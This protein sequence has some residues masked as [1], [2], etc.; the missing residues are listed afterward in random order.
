LRLSD[1]GD[2]FDI[3]DARRRKRRRKGRP[4]A[5]RRI[6]ARE[7]V[8]RV[9]GLSCPLAYWHGAPPALPAVAPPT[10][11]R[12]VNKHVVYIRNRKGHVI[13][14]KLVVMSRS[15]VIYGFY[16]YGTGDDGE[17]RAGTPWI[18][19]VL[20]VFC[21]DLAIRTGARLATTE[22]EESE[23]EA[24]LAL[25]AKWYD[26]GSEPFDEWVF[27]LPASLA[28]GEAAPLPG[29]IAPRVTLTEGESSDQV[30]RQRAVTGDGAVVDL[31]PVVEAVT[32]VVRAI[33]AKGEPRDRHAAAAAQRGLIFLGDEA[34]PI[35]QGE[36][37]VKQLKAHH[38]A[39]IVRHTMSPR[40]RTFLDRFDTGV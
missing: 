22:D 29:V 11:Y 20:D 7:L 40:V 24:D 25:F 33:Q 37:P 26:D 5:K 8:K 14:R 32:R 16:S 34:L 9:E 13:G 12:P 27:A 23:H 1:R 31:R 6:N 2:R 39:Y 4:Y 36:W 21:H 19:I 30:E 10:A 18:K 28:S 15:G 3:D 17:T 35:L 38:L